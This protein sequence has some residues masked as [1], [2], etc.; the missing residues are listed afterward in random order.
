[1]SDGSDKEILFVLG[2]ARS[3]TT[4]LNNFMDRWF[5]Y[6]MG[7]EGTFVDQ[8]YRRLPKYGDLSK[9]HN[10]SRLVED[11][12]RCQMLEIMRTRY[13]DSKRLDV[14]P[15][16]IQARLA[17]PTYA[18]VVYA[19]FQCIADMSGKS[20]VGNKNPGYWTHLSVLHELFPTQ[21]K[22]IAMVRDGRDV[23]LS[24]QRMNWGGHSAFTAARRWHRAQA[25]IEQFQKRHGPDKM[26]V[27]R[28]DD[29]LSAPAESIQQIE[30]F[31]NA[32]LSPET[33]AAALAESN[34]NPLKENFHRWPSRMAESDRRVYEALAG[35][36][37]EKHGYETL[38]QRPT[39]TF[40]EKLFFETKELVRLLKINA[41][42]MRNKLPGDTKKRVRQA[43]ESKQAEN[44]QR[45]VR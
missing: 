1:M 24:L 14:T 37:L 42:H 21:A 29:L 8:F 13:H 18:A 9:A 19:V 44:E 22:Y 2:A 11:V 39:L 40:G 43:G 35:D 31:L 3:G 41:Y 45:A 5:N 7:P 17:E 36:M 23:F 27:L 6:G 16:D 28:Y 20:R 4:Y 34:A 25:A 30:T 32:P 10:L 15:R 38:A 33:R 26:L 12:S